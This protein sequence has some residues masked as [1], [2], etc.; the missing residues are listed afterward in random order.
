MQIK[1]GQSGL[2]NLASSLFM[3]PFSSQ[4]TNLERTLWWVFGVTTVIKLLLAWVFPFTSDEA[5]FVVWG[6]HLD[7]GYY[8][9]GAMTGWWLWAMLQVSDASWWLRLPALLTSTFAG[10]ALWWMLRT[11]DR[12][13]AAWAVILYLVS[14]INAFS[15]LITTDTPLLFFST[16]SV[17]MALR[18]VQRNRMAYFWWSGVALGFAFLSKYFAVLLGLS[19]AVVLLA[20]F[21]RPRIRAL[22]VLLAG[23]IP[24]V[25]INVLWNVHHWW[26]NVLFN[27]VT[28]QESS[29]LSLLTLIGYLAS[30]AALAGPGVI[31]VWWRRR[32]PNTPCNWRAV[33][34]EIRANGLLVPIFASFVPLAI[35]LPVSLF[36][37]IGVHWVLSFFPMLT[38]VLFVRH[39]AVDLRRMVRP[40]L[41][42][43]GVPALL[44]LIAPQLLAFL[45]YLHH[46]DAFSMVLATDPEAVSDQLAPYQDQYLLTTPSYAKSAMFGYHSR[47]NVPVIGFASYH[48]RQD[49]LLTDFRMFEGKDLMIVSDRP[50]TYPYAV[51]WFSE[52]EVIT[53][54][55]RGIDFYVILGR[56]FDFAA[57]RESVLRAIADSY[58]RMPVWLRPFATRCFFTDRYNLGP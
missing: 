44:L 34:P 45:P 23:I 14:P 1:A 7:Y 20:G 18:G 30:L 57:Y 24:G 26:T 37:N 21:G 12:E 50:S 2:A 49:D 27:L 32:S 46:K 38:V 40:T 22:L 39:R 47:R 17:M 33:L 10:W 3:R 5:Y 15:V 9:H 54:K 11:I 43:T 6:R 55:A 13:K 48:G 41:W 28:R 53:L 35:F 19:Y 56:D 8:D 42:W 52:T 36:H 31:L 29:G 51:G 4:P 16:V 58:Y 25:G